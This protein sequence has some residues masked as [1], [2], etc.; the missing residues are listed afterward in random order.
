[1]IVAIAGAFYFLILRPQSK[2]RKQREAQLASVAKGDRIVTIGG[3]VSA[4]GKGT[5]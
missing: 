3:T 5:L 1:M 2:E 4:Q